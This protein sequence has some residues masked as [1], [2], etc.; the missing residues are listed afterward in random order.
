MKLYEGHPQSP[1][2]SGKRMK[3]YFTFFLV[4]SIQ[5]HA[6]IQQDSLEYVNLRG[7]AV[8]V[9]LI[10]PGA[11]DLRT[12]LEKQEGATIC[13]RVST[14]DPWNYFEYLCFAVSAIGPEA[15][16]TYENSPTEELQIAFRDERGRALV[17]SQTSQKITA[18][19]FCRKSSAGSSYT[20]YARPH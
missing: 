13:Q 11:P 2:Q 18:N 7:N 14:N 5:A 20:C 16:Q 15:M 1:L 8:R 19:G 10:R 3:F 12:T 17:G 6:A 9:E 4:L